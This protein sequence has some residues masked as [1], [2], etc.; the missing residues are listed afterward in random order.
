MESPGCSVIQWWRKLL[1]MNPQ[2][3]VTRIRCVIRSRPPPGRTGSPS[4]RFRVWIVSTVSL[5]EVD[6]RDLA[7]LGGCDEVFVGRDKGEPESSGD[8]QVMCV[9]ETDARRIVPDIE[10][11]VD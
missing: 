11:D 8:V 5:G 7:Q 2:P 10:I 1:P 4:R 9:V 3:P 6:D